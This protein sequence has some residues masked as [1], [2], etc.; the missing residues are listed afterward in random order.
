MDYPEATYVYNADGEKVFAHV[1][2]V[3]G[4]LHW[5]YYIGG[6]YEYD[7]PYGTATERLYLGGDAYSAPMVMQRTGNGS[8]GIYNIG[9]DYLGSITDITDYGGAG[10]MAHYRYDPWGRMVNP[11]TGQVYAAGS[12]PSLLLGRG[13]TSHEYLPLFGLIN[14]NARLYDPL[15]GRFLS[16]DSYVRDP[17]NPQNFNRYSY[18]LNNPLR[19]TDEDGEWL[20]VVIGAVVGGIGNLI[21][22]WKNCS[23]FWEYFAAFGVGAAMGAA[24][25]A[26]G[27]AAA[28]AGG[29][30]LATVGV[31]GVGAASGAVNGATSDII[32]QTGENFDGI[33]DLDWDS[34]GVAAAVGGVSGGVGAG[35]GIAMSG[36]HIAVNINGTTVESPLLTSFL[37]GGVAGGAGHVAGGTAAGL[38]M[39]QSLND[40]YNNSWDGIWTSIWTGGAFSAASTAAYCV[41]DGINPLNGEYYD[42]KHPLSDHAKMRMKERNISPTEIKDALQNPL[43]TTEI[44]YDNQGLPSV[45]YIGENSTV[46]VNP[47]TGLIITVYPTS[48][49]T[50]N[51]LKSVK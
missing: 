19:Y 27:G 43:Q 35:V 6:R 50:V 38:L 46:V 30:A 45:K 22:N 51:T 11:S 26:T 36:V 37:A 15:L 49:R 44:R 41:A 12:E 13:F 20:H 9:R 17:D 40:A 7:N 1:S 8:W 31:I 48:T 10:Y 32:R 16:P 29:G 24:V 4:E 2:H 34:V 5:Q 28:A 23:G 42:T 39:G 33:N 3:D 21:G 14:A 25:A 18:C 47:D